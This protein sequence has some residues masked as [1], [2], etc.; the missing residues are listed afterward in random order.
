M[1]LGYRTTVMP[2]VRIGHGA[3][4]AA[5]SVVTSGIPDYAIGR[6]PPMSGSAT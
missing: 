6:L 3:I 4:V 5:G 2:A 1:W